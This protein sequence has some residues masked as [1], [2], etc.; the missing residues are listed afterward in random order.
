MVLA[1]EY[2]KIFAACQIQA[3]HMEISI[4]IKHSENTFEI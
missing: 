2:A 3:K 1:Y 4:K